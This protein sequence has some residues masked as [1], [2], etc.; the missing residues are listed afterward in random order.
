LTSQ[1]YAEV[2]IPHAATLNWALDPDCNGWWDVTDAG[3][4]NVLLQATYSGTAGV[5]IS[6]AT[7]TSFRVVELVVDTLDLERQSLSRHRMNRLLS[8]QIQENPIFFH[9]TQADSQGMRSAVDQLTAIG[10]EMFIYSFG[11]GF[12]LEST[13]PTYLAQIKADIAYANSKGIEVG[14]YDLI[15]LDRSDLPANIQNTNPDGSLGGNAC[16]AS[17]WVETITAKFMNFVDTLGLS[18]VETDG[19]Y[20]GESCASTSHSHHT[21]NADS[22]YWQ[23]R[24]QSDFLPNYANV[25]STFT[26]LI[27]ISIKGVPRQVWGT[28]K[29]STA[30]HDGRI[31]P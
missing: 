29:I 5:D 27:T 9:G 1:L 17:S 20:G 3:A 25:M 19:P 2:D 13:D 7:F 11:S 24:L 12:N 23:N 28:T 22:V 26:N 14:G 16:F 4:A 6:S 31:L 18:A 21:G 15:C 10:F 8:P 30:S